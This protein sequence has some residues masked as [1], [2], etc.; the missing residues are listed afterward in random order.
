MIR[1][2]KVVIGRDILDAVS[3]APPTRAALTDRARQILPVAVGIARSEGAAEFAASLR[4]ESG[5][6]PGAH[7]SEGIRRPFSRV[8]ATSPDA[9]GREHGDV[10]VQKQAIM[11]R[12]VAR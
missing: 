9:V 1:V 2:T 8:I 6:R 5:T 12:A 7:S 11:A 4:I 10:N 3:S